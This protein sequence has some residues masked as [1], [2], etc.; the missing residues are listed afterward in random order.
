MRVMEGAPKFTVLR[1]R[2]DPD[3]PPSGGT[4]RSAG[5]R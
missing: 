1:F 2:T 5:T 4:R 3:V